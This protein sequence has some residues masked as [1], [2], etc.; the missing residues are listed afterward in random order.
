[1]YK[2]GVSSSM[3]CLVRQMFV[4]TFLSHRYDSGFNNPIVL[5]KAKALHHQG[6]MPRALMIRK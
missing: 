6:K 2:L 3:R 5:I 4:G 1:M